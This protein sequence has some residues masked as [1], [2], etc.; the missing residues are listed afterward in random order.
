MPRSRGS[1]EWTSGAASEPWS[2]VVRVKDGCRLDQTE[3]AAVGTEEA[4]FAVDEVEQVAFDPP[5]AS[6]GYFDQ[7]PLTRKAAEGRF[8]H[9]AADG[10]VGA[11]TCSAC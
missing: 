2:K 3:L 5:S 1:T 11:A 10:V 6:G 9:H 4:A 8:E 7:A